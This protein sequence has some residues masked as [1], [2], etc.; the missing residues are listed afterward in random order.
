MVACSCHGYSLFR[1]FSIICV[2]NNDISRVL[3]NSC[4]QVP[5]NP[6]HGKHE[7]DYSILE[8]S[9][10]LHVVTKE[11]NSVRKLNLNCQNQMIKTIINKPNQKNLFHTQSW[12]E[13]IL[14]QWI[15]SVPLIACIS[16]SWYAALITCG[17][18]LLC[19]I[20]TSQA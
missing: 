18:W 6:Y 13:H 1:Y 19:V 4:Y 20:L 8:L 17:L 11:K 5:K 12:E 10:K 14:K 16:L 15:I 9:L 3:L 2:Y 7:M